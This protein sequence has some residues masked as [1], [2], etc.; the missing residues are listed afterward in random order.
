MPAWIYHIPLEKLSDFR[1]T[2]KGHRKTGHGNLDTGKT[3]TGKM[4]TGKMDTGK[5]DTGKMGT[6]KKDLCIYT[7][8]IIVSLLD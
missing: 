3:D 5:M 4:D 6:G 7:T 2:V 8:F 1:C